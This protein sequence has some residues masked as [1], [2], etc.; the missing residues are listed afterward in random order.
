MKFTT[1]LAKI[2][3]IRGALVTDRADNTHRKLGALD[4]DAA[5][6]TLF[7]F[8]A[9]LNTIGETT[10]IGSPQKLLIRGEK[11]ACLSYYRDEIVM[12]HVDPEAD[13]ETIHAHLAD[14]HWDPKEDTQAIGR[15]LDASL[16]VYDS[17]NEQSVEVLP[18]G[19]G[20]QLRY[21]IGVL[22]LG[23]AAREVF[24]DIEGLLTESADVLDESHDLWA[25]Y[26][27]MLLAGDSKVD[28]AS[29]FERLKRYRPNLLLLVNAGNVRKSFANLPAQEL[30]LMTRDLNR[31][32]ISGQAP[33]S[34]VW[35]LDKP[36]SAEALTEYRRQAEVM[37]ISP[38]RAQFRLDETTA[39][40]DLAR[41]EF[42]DHIEKHVV[43]TDSS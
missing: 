34:L 23:V 11:E 30:V 2:G 16:A 9:S 13:V 6:E 24:A 36:L 35:V 31:V 25:T 29:A 27:V 8:E 14:W 21:R 5:S 22:G 28:N 17:S 43:I 40:V 19:D 33:F 41:A 10:G 3:G 15:P 42:L 39:V 32:A 1:M 20:R 4:G 38:A 12:V 7:V 26:E 37:E 18:F